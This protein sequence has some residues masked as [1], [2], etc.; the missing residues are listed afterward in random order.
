MLVFC[1][2]VEG[3]DQLQWSSCAKVG[4][5]G[6][7]RQ[8][9]WFEPMPFYVGAQTLSLNGESSAATAVTKITPDA[10]QACL[11]SSSAWLHVQHQK[12]IWS[13]QHTGWHFSKSPRE[14]QMDFV[15]PKL[16]V[17]VNSM[18]KCASRRVRK[19]VKRQY[20]SCKLSEGDCNKM[21][22]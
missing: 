17:S 12:A 22:Y 4:G 8:L 16:C 9:I 14:L 11:S 13:F 18:C 1:W 15:T 3:A 10:Y 2:E 21:T 20:F 5:G 19:N 6:C 7:V